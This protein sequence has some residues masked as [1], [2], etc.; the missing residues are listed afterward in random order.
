MQHSSNLHASSS[1]SGEAEHVRLWTSSCML[2]GSFLVLNITGMQLS[3]RA[4][5]ESIMHK[6]DEACDSTA[7]PDL[8]GSCFNQ[9]RGP[10]QQKPVRSPCSNP[11]PTES[12]VP[13]GGGGKG[14]KRHEQA[15]QQLAECAAISAVHCHR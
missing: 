14:V 2:L 3:K 6:F 5:I 1:G 13:Q 4:G 12:Q 11:T 7:D 9:L 10:T 8:A 15:L